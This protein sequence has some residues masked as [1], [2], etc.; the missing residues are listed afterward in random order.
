MDW[1]EKV[2]KGIGNKIGG[3]EKNVLVNMVDCIEV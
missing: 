1:R 2:G 3:V